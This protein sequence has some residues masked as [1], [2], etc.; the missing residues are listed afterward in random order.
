MGSTAILTG[1]YSE[2]LVVQLA[3]Y[4][5]VEW[6]RSGALPATCDYCDRRLASEP[7]RRTATMAC[8]ST[9]WITSPP[10]KTAFAV[11]LQTMPG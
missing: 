9:S 2:S 1:I 8:C 10:V 4:L 6:G 11:R 3:R 5:P 7:G